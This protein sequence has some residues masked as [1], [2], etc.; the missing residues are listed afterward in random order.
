MGIDRIVIPN[1]DMIA[2]RR[3][4]GDELKAAIN[5]KSIKK[6]ADRRPIYDDDGKPVLI[7]GNALYRNYVRDLEKALDKFKKEYPEIKIEYGVELPYRP[8][9]S[10][11]QDKYDGL[12]TE[13]IVIDISK[14][15]EIYDLEKPKFSGGGL[16]REQ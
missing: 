14:M 4:S 12:R 13:G 6:D 11:S 10:L 9:M 3:F 2:A 16:V 15:K 1:F 7:E 5:N 8:S